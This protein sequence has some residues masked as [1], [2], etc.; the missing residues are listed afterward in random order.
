MKAYRV[1]ACAS[2]LAVA[3]NARAA[4][5]DVSTEKVK[6]DL[7]Q[8]I[9]YQDW[10]KAAETASLLLASST[11]TPEYRQTL[12]DWRYRFSNY[13]A[14]NTKF[15]QIPNC[16]GVARPVAA[17]P[18]LATSYKPAPDTLI[19][20]TDQIKADLRQAIC[21]QDWNKAADTASLLIAAATTSPEQRQNLVTWRYRFSNYAATNTKFD[22]IPN[23]E[24]VT[25]ALPVTRL[26]GLDRRPE[27]PKVTQDADQIKEDLR[28]AICY[29]DWNKA[30]ETASLLIAAPSTS[31]E[32][33]QTLV[34]WRH[35]FTDY[36]TSNAK[37]DRIP[38]CRGVAP[39]RA[40]SQAF[41]P[42][43]ATAAPQFSRYSQPTTTGQGCYWVTPQG[44]TV[45][46]ESMCSGAAQA[47]GKAGYR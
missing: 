7:R 2:L 28:Q 26:P 33:R 14:T 6:A 25:T 11:I 5:A 10:D 29:Q 3:G 43:S 16:E 42:P 46:L 31:A 41:E 36:A 22:Q 44:Q 39:P 35:R 12:V 27:S 38:N 45:S 9:C 13:A 23:C 32:H 37:F 8:A 24:G 20:D 21:Y 34:T 47:A 19:Q 4:K 15:D 40:D 17:T 30:A 18:A 1:V